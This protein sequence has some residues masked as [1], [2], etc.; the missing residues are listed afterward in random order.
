MP[1]KR[2][3]PKRLTGRQE[4]FVSEYLVDGVGAYAALRAGLSRKGAKETA[5]RMLRKPHVRAEVD[6]RQKLLAEK[7][8]ERSAWDRVRLL[9][10]L[11]TELVA[12]RSEGDYAEAHRILTTIG[13]HVD[14][15]AFRER[16]VVEHTGKVTTEFTVYEGEKPE[17]LAAI[18]QMVALYS[19]PNAA[20]DP[21]RVH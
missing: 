3:R 16:S 19:E 15:G 1:A 18:A 6:R 17:T 8:T 9:R 11:D 2:S 10:E 13:K 12:A 7:V 21:A 20:E 14:I 5:T 4:R